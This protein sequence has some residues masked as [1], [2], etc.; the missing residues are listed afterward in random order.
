[1]KVVTVVTLSTAVT[2]GKV[3]TVEIVVTVFT[4]GTVVTKNLKL[5]ILS[6]TKQTFFVQKNVRY[7]ISFFF[8]TTI[9][10]MKK[11]L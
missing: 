10:V 7:L 8:D 9:Q 1:M 5:E 4:V 3:E 11:K 6:L 2:V